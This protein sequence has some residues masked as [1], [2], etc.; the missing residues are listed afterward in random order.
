M[1]EGFLKG[2]I[3]SVGQTLGP[4]VISETITLEFNKRKEDFESPF[5]N[6][7]NMRMWRRI[8]YHAVTG[9]NVPVEDM[10]A[11]D[12]AVYQ[13]AIVGRNVLVLFDNRVRGFGKD[14]K[15]IFIPEALGIRM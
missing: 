2:K 12:F 1:Q 11:S 14:D 8:V 9:K 3:I 6:A 13:S 5:M 7:E 4:E 15:A 10:H